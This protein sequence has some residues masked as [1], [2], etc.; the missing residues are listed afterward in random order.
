MIDHEPESNLWLATIY[1]SHTLSYVLSN[2]RGTVSYPLHHTEK[3]WRMYHC[4]Y[5]W[6]RIPF[7]LKKDSSQFYLHS[8]IWYSSITTL[9]S[10]SCRTINFHIFSPTVNKVKSTPWRMRFL[11]KVSYYLLFNLDFNFFLGA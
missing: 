4:L 2:D 9:I 3:Q 10:I 1:E 7:L 8:Y 5:L 6:T 11:K